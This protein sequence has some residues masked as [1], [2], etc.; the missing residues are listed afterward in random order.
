M[1]KSE[2]Q[3]EIKLNSENGDGVSLPLPPELAH[4]SYLSEIQY[5]GGNEWSA[6]C[7]RCGGGSIKDETDQY[8]FYV[9]CF[10]LFSDGSEHHGHVGCSRCEY[11]GW[12]DASQNRQLTE[13]EIA[14]YFRAGAKRSAETA[15]MFD[16]ANIAGYRD[17][18]RDLL[19][20]LLESAGANG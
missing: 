13:E 2:P 14:G 8:K 7:P 6:V 3:K 19:A 15:D 11:W 4:Y 16:D 17:G 5:L 10:R 18:R 12:A 9:G 1:D 20:Y